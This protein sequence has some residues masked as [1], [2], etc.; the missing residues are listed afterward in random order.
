MILKSIN[1]TQDR[2]GL[3]IVSKK[4]NITQIFFFE[5][6]F[7][8]EYFTKPEM[9]ATAASF[10]RSVHILYQMY[11]CSKFQSLQLIGSSSGGQIEYGNISS[12]VFYTKASSTYNF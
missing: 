12:T 1:V 5:Q 8:F 4:K 2:Q 10:I 11:I 9:S 7:A 6:M 3:N